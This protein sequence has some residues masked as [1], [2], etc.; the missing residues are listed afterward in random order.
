MRSLQTGRGR[1]GGGDLAPL[2]YPLNNEDGPVNEE[3]DPY[4]Y[5]DYGGEHWHG[6]FDSNF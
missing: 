4:K 1:G 2:V 3:R 5:W 6:L